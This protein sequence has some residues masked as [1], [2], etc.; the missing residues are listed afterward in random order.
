MHFAGRRSQNVA[1][2]AVASAL[3]ALVV[4]WVGFRKSSPELARDFEEC[5]EQVQAKALSKDERG[6]LMTKC[7]ALFAGRRKPGGGYTY[8]DFM[9]DRSF[10]IAGPNPTPTNASR[11]IASTWLSSTPNGE[12]L[13]RR[14]WQKD[15]TNNSRPIWKGRA[16]PAG[17]RRHLCREIR[18]P[19]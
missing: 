10:D 17:H 18:L 8:Y 12:R 19:P 6:A 9:Q 15:E 1:C 7:S 3:L 11:S 2:A 14:N 5:V 4:W 16:N 13:S